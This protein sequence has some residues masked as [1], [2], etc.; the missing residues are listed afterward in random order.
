MFCSISSSDST[1]TKKWQKKNEKTVKF[2][3]F[4]LRYFSTFRSYRFKIPQKP[5]TTTLTFIL[6]LSKTSP[7]P[8]KTLWN[9]K[10]P[11][12][13]LG[14]IMKAWENLTRKDSLHILTNS[15]QKLSLQ[16]QEHVVSTSKLTSIWL[17]FRF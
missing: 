8:W 10:K 16:V 14:K 4:K 9:F 13:N 5:A 7:K 17:F 11:E 1:V 2:L 15:H 3:I 6:N 12:E